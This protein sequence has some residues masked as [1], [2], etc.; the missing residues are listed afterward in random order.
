VPLWAFL[1]LLIM[2][3]KGDLK[4]WCFKHN[5]ERTINGNRSKCKQCQKENDANRFFIR[6]DFISTCQYCMINY[7]LDVKTNNRYLGIDINKFC[8]VKCRN[9]CNSFNNKNYKFYD[10]KYKSTVKRCIE[11]NVIYEKISRYIVFE[12]YNYTCNICK[13][14]CKKPNKNNYNDLDCATVDHIIPKVKGGTHTYDNVQLLCRNCNNKK[15]IN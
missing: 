7:G 4:Q 3:K 1:I 5:I 9:L 11:N 15:S 10:D 6:N 8:S 12:N 2:T 13:I 14:I